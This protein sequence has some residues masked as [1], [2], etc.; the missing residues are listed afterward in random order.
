MS[1]LFAESFSCSLFI[2]NDLHNDIFYYKSRIPFYLFFQFLLSPSLPFVSSHALRQS[3]LSHFSRVISSS[4]SP[5]FLFFSPP[6]LSPLF[7]CLFLPFFIR[8]LCLTCAVFMNQ[9]RINF[10]P[11]SEAP[12][13]SRCH[14]NPSRRCSGSA[15][16]RAGDAEELCE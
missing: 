10:R 7:I 4:W 3:A 11:S 16:G 12:L 14:D 13:P 15:E 2:C 9:N 5:F 1:V 8:T 6:P